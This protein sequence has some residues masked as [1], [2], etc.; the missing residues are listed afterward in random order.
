MN[1]NEK[2]TAAIDHFLSESGEV[3]LAIKGGVVAGTRPG[4]ATIVRL[5][6]QMDGFWWSQ[7]SIGATVVRDGTEVQ[8]DVLVEEVIAAWS[9]DRS[10]D[11]QV[12]GFCRADVP[13]VFTGYAA[14]IREWGDDEEETAQFVRSRD[15]EIRRFAQRV[16]GRWSR[17]GQA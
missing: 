12:F 15:G 14:Q 11:G 1:E 3:W 9:G 16:L 2:L 10:A 5:D 7:G 13:E 4:G 17:G 8:V 6:E